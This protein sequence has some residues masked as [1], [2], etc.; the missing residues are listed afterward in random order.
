[1]F[2]CGV[3]SLVWWCSCWQ[4]W[5]YLFCLSLCVARISFLVVCGCEFHDYVVSFSPYYLLEGRPKDR[6]DM[7]RGTERREMEYLMRN[8]NRGIHHVK[9]HCLVYGYMLQTMAQVVN[10]SSWVSNR[11][12]AVAFRSEHAT[13]MN[14]PTTKCQHAMNKGDVSAKVFLCNSCIHSVR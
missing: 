12:F 11:L 6:K 4:W 1:M 8:F 3:N 2:K 5:W 9:C 7:S 10:D 14:E 13:A